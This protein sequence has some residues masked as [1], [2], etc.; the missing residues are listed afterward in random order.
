MSNIVQVQVLS[1]APFIGFCRCHG[2]RCGLSLR[3]QCGLSYSITP[4]KVI[5]SKVTNLSRTKSCA[6]P[7]AS[8]F[9]G[10]NVIFDGAARSRNKAAAACFAPHSLFVAHGRRN[11]FCAAGRASNFIS[12]AECS[13]RVVASPARRVVVTLPDRRLPEVTVTRS[14][15]SLC[16]K[17]VTRWPLFRLTVAPTPPQPA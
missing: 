7:G 17:G 9:H 1:W 3:S 4:L 15:V 2:V 5:S 16:Q 6:S 8:S 11:P 14:G 13:G 12:L 10:E